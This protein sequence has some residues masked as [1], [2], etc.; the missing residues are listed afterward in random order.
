MRTWERWDRGAANLFDRL[1]E[2]LI[3]YPALALV[4]VLTLSNEAYYRAKQRL[5]KARSSIELG[6]NS[7][8][9]EV[10]R[11]ILAGLGISEEPPADSGKN[12][13]LTSKL[14]PP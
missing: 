5:E 2:P 4:K 7:E 1:S 12:P 10:D 8:L 3:Y 14:P 9:T 6:Y 13:T 11:T